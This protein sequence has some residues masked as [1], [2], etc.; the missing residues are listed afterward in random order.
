MPAELARSDSGLQARVIDGTGVFT[1]RQF[2]N[3]ERCAYRVLNPILPF[4]TH[5]PRTRWLPRKFD[6]VAAEPIASDRCREH[7][8]HGS[9][10]SWPAVEPTIRAS[11]VTVN[12][13]RGE[14]PPLALVRP[15]QRL[16]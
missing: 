3:R 12:S 13:F 8:F 10:N 1:P 4:P 5:S 14:P 7:T 9:G 11:A 2:Q 6:K 15:T 16:L